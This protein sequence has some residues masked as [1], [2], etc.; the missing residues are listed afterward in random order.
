LSATGAIPPNDRAGSVQ[1]QVIVQ[2]LASVQHS[3]R[4]E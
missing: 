4:I 2:H 3:P 1:I